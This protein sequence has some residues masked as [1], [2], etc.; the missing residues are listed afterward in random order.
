MNR[1][2]PVPTLCIPRRQTRELEPT[3]IDEIDGAV[4]Q[5]APDQRRNRVDDVAKLFF[6][7]AGKLFGALAP[8]DVVVDDKDRNM[9]A[10]FV[11]LQ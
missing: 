5:C 7:P 4:G 9:R 2:F 3:V 10:A 6:A 1:G 11:T 8:G